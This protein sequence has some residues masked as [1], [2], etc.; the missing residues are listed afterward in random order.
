MAKVAAQRKRVAAVA[1]DHDA[2]WAALLGAVTSTFK[3]V[4]GPLFCTDVSG[5]NDAF[6][7]HCG[8]ERE[9]HDCYAC[10]RFIE[11]YG[12][13]VTIA[14]DGHVASAFWDAEAVPEFYRGAAAAMA[15]A[16]AKARVVGVFLASEKVLGTPVTGTWTH[17]SVKNPSVYARG[18][19]TAGQAMAAKREDHHT[20]AR[21]LDE[22]GPKVIA[23][24]ERLFA[25]EKLDRP[26]RFLGPLA[27]L[28][29]LHRARA[30]A[31]DARLR[32]NVLWRAVATAPDAFCH[33]KAS[34]L[35]QLMTSIAE[36]KAFGAIKAEFEAM[37]HPL[38]YQ[39][40]V[41]APRGQALEQAE[42]L[43]AE[44][45]LAPSLERRYARLDDCQ[46][47]WTPVRRHEAPHAR[48]VFGHLRTRDGVA[49]VRVDAPATTMTWDKFARVVLPGA[50]EMQ[51]YVSGQMGFIALTTA[52]HEDA[53]RILKWD[54]P[55]AWYVYNGGS[56][57]SAWGLSTG[58]T[59]VTGIVPLPPMWGESPQPHLGDGMILVLRGCVD[60][61][62]CGNAL[63]P[64]C[65]R[66][67]MHSV[68]SVIE[69]YS[70]GA[71][72]SGREDA[73]ACGLDVRKQTGAIGYR[74]RVKAGGAWTDYK[75]DRWD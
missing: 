65:L 73:S 58:W 13:L 8:A 57:A 70:R 6:L 29:E 46:L 53:P 12:G 30:E 69:A 43:F 40:P 22:F 55:V 60:S 42:K 41:A 63:F 19:L 59:D 75:I 64:E 45:G 4:R 10:R 72:L 31:K 50:E 71:K 36:G 66:G 47:A 5:L 62:E 9:I 33:V 28:G 2:D 17:L 27:W 54:H 24:A 18:V 37:V 38:R 74:L 56:P 3:A 35:G 21:A 32:D 23:E 20:V 26:E 39:R 44:M 48:G 51:A 7:K 34:V 11:N 67:E 49:D 1:H 61:R 25:A 68:R 52:V 14:D 16:V 15:K